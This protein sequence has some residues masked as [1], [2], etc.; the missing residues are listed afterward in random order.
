M[1]ATGLGVAA[2]FRFIAV[3][4]HLPL[5]RALRSRPVLNAL[6]TTICRAGGL[7]TTT[8]GAGWTV[9]GAFLFSAVVA[10][11][12]HHVLWGAH[13]NKDC[14]GSTKY[15]SLRSM[16]GGRI[17]AWVRTSGRDRFPR[18]PQGFPWR[19]PRQWPIS[20]VRPVLV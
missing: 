20:E 12:R 15:I 14:Q 6:V 19:L 8:S 16:I 1:A 17:E 2:L 10:D 11:L 13:A 18:F 4:L 7:E 5:G 3:S 9:T